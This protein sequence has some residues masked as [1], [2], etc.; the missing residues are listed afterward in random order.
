MKDSLVKL[1]VFVPAGYVERVAS[2]MAEAGGGIIGAYDAC[3]FRLNGKGTFRGS[4]KSKPFMGKSGRLEEV[5][6]TRLEM[7]APRARVDAIV[8]A[9]KSVHP[10]EEVAYDLYT[11]ENTNPNFGMGAVGDLPRSMTVKEFLT[12][13]KK[14]IRAESVR[15]SGALNQRIRRVAVCGG[16]GSELLDQAIGAKADI[17]V[18]AESGTTRSTTP[19]AALSLSTPATGKPSKVCFRCSR[20]NCARGRHYRMRALLFQL[21]S[22]QQTQFILTSNIEG[23]SFGKP[24]TLVVWPSTSRLES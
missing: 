9:L 10:Y 5:E 2:A 22:I 17:F 21:L 7:I 15:Y 23:V 4:D 24:I 3:S 18:T 20:R 6:E 12:K 16:A 19:Q 1:A 11:V 13:L 14:A 8:A